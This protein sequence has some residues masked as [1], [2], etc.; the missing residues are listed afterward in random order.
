[1]AL[2][3]GKVEPPR[4]RLAVVAARFNRLVTERLVQGALRALEEHGVDPERVDL[5]WVPGSFELPLT[6]QRLAATHR[7][8]AVIC[9]GCVIRGETDH[10]LYVA[11]ETARGLMEAGLRTGVPV[12]LGV[13]TTDTVEQALARAGPGRGNKGYEAAETALAMANLLGRITGPP[14]TGQSHT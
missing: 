7:Y 12:V 1:M 4:Q 5:V 10:Y 2:Y 8:A 3:E 13:L 11:G 9:L 14:G 6:A